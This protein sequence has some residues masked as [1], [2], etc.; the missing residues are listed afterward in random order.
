MKS[1]LLRVAAGADGPPWV[2]VP[3]ERGRMPGR[4]AH[5][6]P[7]QGCLDQAVRRKAFARALRLE[8]AIDVSAVHTWMETRGEQGRSSA[9]D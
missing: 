1:D 5:L 3:D 8:G 6:H 7:R 9:E 4:G 2:V